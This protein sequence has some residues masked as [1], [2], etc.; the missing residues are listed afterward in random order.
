MW[1]GLHRCAVPAR[2]RGGCACMSSM[3]GDL[4]DHAVRMS[5]SEQQGCATVLTGICK[6]LVAR[7]RSHVA[8]KK[9]QAVIMLSP[10]VTRPHFSA[11]SRRIFHLDVLLC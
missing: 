3:C 11:E 7:M 5:E 4:D 8:R 6:Q 2:G 1:K 10:V 9:N